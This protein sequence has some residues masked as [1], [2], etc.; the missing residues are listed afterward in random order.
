MAIESLHVHDLKSHPVY[1]G[2]ALAGR[3]PFEIRRGD[4]DFR[5]GDYTLEREWDPTAKRY[6]GRTL[7]RRIISVWQGVTGL[8]RGYRALGLER[9]Y[10]NAVLS[11]IL[12]GERAH[13]AVIVV[14][15]RPAI[16]AAARETP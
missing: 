12:D 11:A 13:F 2:A 9:E 4:R 6:T 8:D 7:V 10:G 16:P 1:F 14:Q 5:N 3:K 15:H